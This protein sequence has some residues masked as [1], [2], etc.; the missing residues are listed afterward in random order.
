[1]KAV[2]TRDLSIAPE[3]HTVFHYKAGE[4]ITGKVAELALA[5]GAAIEIS[6]IAPFEK[7]VE[8]PSETKSR[9][10]KSKNKV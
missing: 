6:D 10:S 1:M 9:T 2:L 3:G 4:Q 5:D 7:K 8:I